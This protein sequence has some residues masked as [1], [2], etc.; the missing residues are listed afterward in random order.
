MLDA[1]TTHLEDK[2]A[3]RSSQHG[4]TTD[5][6]RLTNPIAFYDETTTCTYE[7]EVVDIV[8]LD[9]S[10]AF[11]TLTF[12]TSHYILLECCAA[13]QRDLERSERWAEKN[14]LKS[15]KS[16]C[17][18]V[19]LGKNNPRHQYRLGADLLES[20]SAQNLLGVLVNNKLSMSQQCA[21]VA[22]IA[23]GILGFIRKS[24]VTREVV[25]PLYSAWARLHFGVLC[26][27]LGSL[28]KERHGAP[29]AG[30]VESY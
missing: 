14:L 9:F 6:S 30:P 15:S 18:V 13:L 8:Y 12:N 26:P 27:V 24:I 11:S 21:L 5:K 22:K 19:H 3:I 20:S 2:R 25:L 1:I 10:K 23:S 28:V 29:G 7:G 4:F 17:R 16:K